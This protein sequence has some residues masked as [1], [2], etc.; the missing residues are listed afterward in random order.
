MEIES[1]AGFLIRCAENSRLTSPRPIYQSLI[2]KSAYQLRERHIPQLAYMCRR[3][4]DEIDQL[5][6]F[7]Y[8]MQGTRHWK[9]SGEYLSKSYFLT[10]ASQKFCPCCMNEEPYWR[11]QWDL[12][13]YLACPRH[14]IKLVNRCR[15]C[16]RPAHWSRARLLQCRCGAGFGDQRA[17]ADTPGIHFISSLIESKVSGTFVDGSSIKLPASVAYQ[18]ANSSL[19]SLFKVLW[20]FG[21]TLPAM[22]DAQRRAAE[23]K[24]I[25]SDPEVIV[26]QAM[27]FLSA[28]PESFATAI[29]ACFRMDLSN[30]SASRLEKLFGPLQRYLYKEMGGQ[31]LRHITLAYEQYVR[32]LF[33]LLAQPSHRLRITQQIEI[34]FGGGNSNA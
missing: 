17:Q 20:L 33:F 16:N 14:R 22:V 21:R 9:I 18:L 5:F 7:G 4:A 32:E 8:W 15:Q 25:S 30:S 6:G 13:F 23:P 1:L 19:D 2:G 29:Q 27:E 26:N 28:W 11:G 24:I 31:E 3:S 12:T 10:Y 34:D